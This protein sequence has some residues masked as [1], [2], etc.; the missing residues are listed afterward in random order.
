MPSKLPSLACLFILLSIASLRGDDSQ[1]TVLVGPDAEPMQAGKFEPTW[2][3]LSQYETPDWFRDAKFGIWAHWGPQCEPE[4]GDWYAR[5]M[6]FENERQGKFHREHYGHPS[7]F[8]FKDVINQWKAENWDPEKLIAL[9]KRAGAKYF[10]ALANHHDNFDNYNSKYQ[11]WNA[12]KMGPKKDL[13][14]GWAKAARAAGLRFGVSV[15]ASHAWTWYEGS[16]GSDKSGPLAGAAYDG[17]LTKADGQGQWWEGYDPQD[18]YA[19]NH[20]PSKNFTNSGAIHG[21][22]GWDANKGC[23]IPDAAYC[24]KFY[25]RTVD[26][27]NK[28]QPDLL[29]FDDTA[30]PLWPISD[31]GLRIAADFYNSNMLWHGGKLEAVLNGKILNQQQRKCMVWDI[32]RGQSNQ[33]EPFVWQTDT[34]LGSWHYDIGV[35]NSHHYKSAKTVIH[36]LADIVSKNGNLLLSVPVRAD[37]TIDSDEIKIIEGVAAWMD[38]NGESIFC[39]RPWKVFGEGPAMQSAAPLSAQGFNEGKGKPLAADDIR[40]TRKGDV[41]YAIA[42]GKPKEALK[43]VS[44]GKKAG[45]LEKSISKV[46]LLGSDEELKWEQGDDALVIECPQKIPSDIALAFKIQ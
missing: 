30:L 35:F 15:H 44:L 10:V 6:Y 12:T 8:G 39:T 23:S 27:I 19:Q 22:W 26:L 11:P 31:A 2:Q 20:T 40:F 41:L 42:L 3:S 4:Q 43:I 18:L 29:Y 46:Q 34:C 32:E 45:L 37:G 14:G 36:T 9:Y 33:I 1:P 17:K 24:Q 7:Q 25:N 13:I 38:I 28:Y 16:Q 21:F 5:H